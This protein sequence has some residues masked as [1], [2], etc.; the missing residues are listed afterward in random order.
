ML[1]KLAA[2]ASVLLLACG[3]GGKATNSKTTVSGTAAKPAKSGGAKTQ[4]LYDRLGGQRAIVAV[5]DDFI[6]RVAA[7]KRIN[8]R[9]ANTDIP[10]LKT[11]LV[12]FVCMATGGPCR[13]SG[14]DMETSHAGMEIVEEEFTALVE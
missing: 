3:G 8:Q 10:Q 5:V 4:E 6:G 7:D 11:L 14:R 1:N 9:F 12:E 2:V 13:Y